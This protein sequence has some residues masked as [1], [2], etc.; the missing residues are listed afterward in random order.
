MGT[1][2]K[3]LTGMLTDAMRLNEGEMVMV[4]RAFRN[5]LK[6]VGLPIYSTP[7]SIRKLLITLV[8]EP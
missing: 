5:W 8:D 2:G 1:K 6:E 3:T 4:K 7:E